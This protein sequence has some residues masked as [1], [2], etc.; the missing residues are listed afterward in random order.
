MMR[1]FV[2]SL[3]TVVAGLTG[4]ALLM[5]AAPAEAQEIQLTG[6]L[7]G[8]PAVRKLR[9]HRD[10]RFE[11][12]PG[13][14]F[15]L[16][17]EYR[18][19]IMP[20]MRLTYHLTDWLGIGAWGGYGFQY[21]TGL[22][23]ELQSVAIGARDCANRSF[24]KECQLT[25]VNLTRGNLTE[26]QLAQIQWV[27]A[28]QLTFVPF[29]GKLALFAELFVDT[30][31]NFFAGYAAVGV[32]ERKECTTNCANTFGLESRVAFAPTFGLGLNFYPSDFIGFGA[33]WRALPFEWN[34]SGFDNHGLGTDEAFPDNKVDDKDR[35]FHFTSMV[36]VSLSIQLP[37]AIKTTE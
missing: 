5:T 25:R 4:C 35:E 21:N 12:A 7:A 29:R 8:A 37:A 10:G 23:D 31:V 26:D 27:A 2:Q 3:C 34:T 16:L 14:S 6:P 18:R 15:T 20:G 19:T 9:L 33:E 36:T 22:T 32:K 24:T 1:R 11:V 13:A 17:D 28:P 30:D